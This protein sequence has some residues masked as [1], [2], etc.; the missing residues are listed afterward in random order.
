MF[1]PLNDY[2]AIKPDAEVGKSKG[3]ILLPDRAKKKP[4]SGKVLAV[5]PGRWNEA[6]TARIP[7]RVKV[8]DTAVYAE[9]AGFE[10]DGVLYVRDDDIY[11]VS[12]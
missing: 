4:I 12:K 11:A 9:G 1:Q 10:Q 2:V 5:G 3:G 6:V 8:D 7:V